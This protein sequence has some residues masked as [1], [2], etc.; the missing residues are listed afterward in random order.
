MIGFNEIEYASFTDVGI[1]RSHNQ[2]AHAVMPATDDEHWQQIGHVFLVADGMGGHAVGELAAKIAVDNIPHIFSKYAREGPMPALRRAFTDANSIIHTRG[3]QNREFKGLGTTGTAVV[4]RPEG[5]WVGHVGDSRAYRI[6]GGVIEQLTFD[7]SLLWELARRQ[8]KN[9]D[10]L[11]GIQSNIISRS[12]GSLPSVEVDVEGPHPLERGDIFLMCSD[13][14]SGQ[15][16][17]RVI[18]SVVAALPPAEAVRFLVHMANL[19]GGP[20]NTTVIVVRVGGE[21]RSEMLDSKAEVL[22]P[23]GD[24]DHPIVPRFALLKYYLGKLPWAPLLAF[25]LLTVGILM[26]IL[27]T[28]LAAV[29][30]GAYLYAFIVAGLALLSGIVLLMVQNFRE[31]RKLNN[32]PEERPLQVYRQTPCPLDAAIYEKLLQSATALEANIKE[33]LWQYDVKA[34]QDLA[35]QAAQHHQQHHYRDAFRQQCRAM[36][37]LMEAVHAYRGKNEDF[38]PLW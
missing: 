6:R 9:P 20:D 11:T 16:H 1:R 2:D 10:E 26:G 8:R 5:A 23:P 33:K 22:F 38:K 34:Y 13:G 32:E 3:Q 4:L 27:A 37:V 24:P 21:P 14:L 19:Q 30:H 18:G 15:V 29:Q 35:K 36:L 7:H 28:V 25:L 17:D 31:T 12:L